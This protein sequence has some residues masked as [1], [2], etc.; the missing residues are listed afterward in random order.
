MDKQKIE[1]EIYKVRKQ[2]IAEKKRAYEKAKR[3]RLNAPCSRVPEQ[4]TPKSI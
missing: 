2:K 1:E 3:E 4:R